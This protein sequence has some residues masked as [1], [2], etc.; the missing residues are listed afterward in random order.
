[1]HL[2]ASTVHRKSRVSIYTIYSGDYK[3]TID[4]YDVFTPLVRHIYA[5]QSNPVGGGHFRFLSVASNNL[6]ILANIIYGETSGSRM[7]TE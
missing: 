5:L 2:L 4:R 7:E 1:M 6:T 3:R